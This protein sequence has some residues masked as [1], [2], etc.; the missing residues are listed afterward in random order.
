MEGLN[1]TNERLESQ[2][3]DEW[4]T[5]FRPMEDLKIVEFKTVQIFIEYSKYKGTFEKLSQ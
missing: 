2:K 3:E 4:S 1:M 5:S